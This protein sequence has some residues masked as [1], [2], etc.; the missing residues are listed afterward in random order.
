MEVSKQMKLLYTLHTLVF[1]IKSTLA[2]KSFRK[3][4][5]TRLRFVTPK[6]AKNRRLQAKSMSL[7]NCPLNRKECRIDLPVKINYTP[8]CPVHDGK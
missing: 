8:Q 3:I 7:G 6:E 2:P 1:P 4:R 5:D